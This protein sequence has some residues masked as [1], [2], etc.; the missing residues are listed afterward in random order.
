[1][2]LIKIKTR[3]EEYFFDKDKIEF[4]DGL[5][6]KT[7]NNVSSYLINNEYVV[8]SSDKIFFK[9]GCGAIV[10]KTFANFKNRKHD[11]CISCTRKKTVKEV[12]NNRSKEEKKILNEKISKKTKQAMNNISREKRNEMTQ[13]MIA[14]MDWEK[15]NKKWKETMFNKSQEEKNEIYKKV[16]ITM[17]QKYKDHGPW[18][19]GDRISISSK[20]LPTNKWFKRGIHPSNEIIAA[21][22]NDCGREFASRRANLAKQ[23]NNHPGFIYCNNCKVNGERNPGY[24]DG[25]KYDGNDT[26]T[27]LFYNLKFRDKI[28][29]NQNYTCPICLEE[30]SSNSH[31]HHIDYDKKN[32]NEN[33]LIFLHLSCH[34]KTNFNREFWKVFFENHNKNYYEKL[35]IPSEFI[36]QYF[37]KF[38]LINHKFSK[39][40]IIKKLQYR[41][42]FNPDK[43]PSTKGH[44]I[45]KM[46]NKKYFYARKRKNNS[47]IIENISSQNI[48]KI[49]NYGDSL[50]N[51]VNKITSQLYS[52][53][54][55]LFSH[56]IMDW[57]LTKWSK[58][59]DT[60]YDPAGGFG[61]R[62]IGT[63]HHN[64]KYIT[65]DPWTYDE[66][67]KINNILNLNAI[68]HDKKSEDLKM[69]CDMVICCPPY[70]NDEN[71]EFIE[72]REYNTWL[73][74]YWQ[75]TLDNIDSNRFVLI[76][77][78]KYPEMIKMV[79]NKWKE[80][81]RFIIENKSFNS[82][83]KE[84][85]IYF[86]K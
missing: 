16:S 30:L 63:Y 77:G 80:K 81:E 36:E 57:I 76:M 72:E 42:K 67:E 73:Q 49:Y 48:L 71:Y 75:K 85:I 70:Y 47:S 43:P 50:S 41:R 25:R 18:N 82:V 29:K 11:L 52:F 65:T 24:I 32:D 7:Q 83:N 14:S 6:T 74:E 3:E 9:C 51:I 19:V 23:E 28:L 84:Y 38:P 66:L 39:Q 64:I 26:Y 68:I 15:R 1:M 31:L 62:A 20:S 54:V 55:S 53:P 2:K 10:E 86:E 8:I 22:C 4:K 27:S 61:G 56:H 58:N 5:K 35:F 34:M 13:K 17:R 12:H 60:I 46:L 44:N 33:N 45:S 40:E 78:E 69:K 21:E 37:E 59:G 79:S